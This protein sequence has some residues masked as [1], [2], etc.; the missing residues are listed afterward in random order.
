MSDSPSIY[1]PMDRRQAL[2]SGKTLPDRTVGAALF[3]DISGFTP[4]TEGLAK[5]LGRRRG[6]EELTKQLN[7]IYGGLITEVE[8][9]HGSVIGFSGD[10]ITCWLDG[11]DGLRATACAL[12]MQQVMQQ[13]ETIRTPS[14]LTFPLAIKVAIAA[15]PARRFRVGDLK[16]Q[17]WDVLAGA[18]L[19][20]LAA[21]EHEAESGEVVISAEVARQLDS[22]LQISEWRDDQ[23]SAARFAVVSGLK[24]DL[25]A[26][27]WPT[28]APDALPEEI[29]RPWVLPA[30]YERVKSGQ[31]RFQ[32]ELRPAVAL[33]LRFGGIDYDQD[34]EAGEKLDAYVH[35]VQST[36]VRY[37]GALLQLTIGDK[38]SYIYLAFGAP[39][40]H[41]DD[42]ARAALAALQ[43]RS[44][45]PELAFIEAAQIG[46]S[47]GRMRVGPYGSP[48]RRT[49][50][51]LGEHTNLAARLM[52]N[53]PPGDVLVSLA[54]QKD[55][56]A[57]FE[58]EDCPPLQV[59]G[60]AEPVI[61]FRLV[62]PNV[63][64]E[65]HLKESRY[66]L[67]LVG[68]K[69]E[70]AQVEQQLDHVF[71]GRGQILGIT[72][73]AGLGKSRLVAEIVRRASDQQMD[74]LTGECQ[75]YGTNISYHV[76]W[77]I[78]H[79]FFG[80]DPGWALEKQ[81]RSLEASLVAVS[82]RLARRLPLLGVVLNLSIP[83]N[84]LTQSMDAELRKASLEALL[85]D[86][87]RV[88]AKMNPLVFVL[89]DAHWLDPL[90]N[91]LLEVVGRA[92]ANLP[93]LILM[94]Y[95]PPELEHLQGPRVVSLPHCTVMSLTD[96]TPGEAERLIIL[97]LAQ[98]SGSETKL[99]TVFIERITERAQ[100]NPFYIEELVNYL[101]DRGID[102]SQVGALE[103]IDLPNSLHS[104]ILSRIDRL[105]ESQ[106]ITLKVASIIGRLFRRS[107][108]WGVDPELGEQTQVIADLQELSRIDLTPLDQVEPDE[109]YLFK[110]IVTREVAYESLPFATRALLHGQLG[111]FIEHF[112]AQELEQYVEL[113]AY[114]YDFSHLED[115]KREYLRKAG[116]A[117][118]AA[119][120]NEPAIDY[121]RRL[122]PLLPEDERM[123]ILLKLG[124]VLELVGEWGDAGKL[125]EQ[126]LTLA[127][128]QGNQTTLAE[129][130][131]D[132]G[133]LRRKEGDFAGAE[134]W[135]ERARRN[136][137][138][139]GDLAGAGRVLAE[140]GEVYRLKGDY[141]AAETSFQESLLLTDTVEE[142]RARL[143]AR[144]GVLKSAGTLANQ[145]G[146][147]ARARQMYEE[148][149]SILRELDDKPGVA[150]L[151][152]NLGVVAMHQEDYPTAQPLYEESLAIM[153]EIGYRWAVGQLLNNLAL[154][155]RY[156][157]DSVTAREML[158]ESVAVRRA[159][160]D[161]WGIANSLSSLTNLL[162][163]LSKYE[164]V[165]D[166]LDESLR[167]NQELGDRTAIAYCLEDFASLA[168]GT[169]HPEQALRL[170][171]AAA[172]LRADIGG[173]LAAGEQAALDRTLKPARAS[174]DEQDQAA[175]WES[176]Q[177]LSMEV[178]IAEALQGQD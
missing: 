173:P 102:P 72:A 8:R 70:L 178:A 124:D 136:F 134:T 167:I 174:L 80:L 96:F 61:V 14:G 60:K 147:L 87:V 95:R 10:A 92:I 176:G 64:Q 104:L 106:K 66:A 88:R 90:S 3:A 69:S 41:E 93:V 110:H 94:A 137:E 122:L 127:E 32:A 163:H 141:A 83:H 119:Y 150:S 103:Q 49:Y 153:R 140:I 36:A 20:R 81:V 145:Q 27:P 43:L 166:M 172:A 13:F 156:Q 75:S 115:K 1:I 24:R 12:S 5:E 105:S 91:D 44:T 31:D 112:Y 11:D 9:Y 74:I 98:V 78:W 37:D 48:E 73:E 47:K 19:D 101:H 148:S 158:E 146:D 29:V 85:V 107:W 35:W 71:A 42:A 89:D 162:V 55:A 54:A 175:A 6:A 168:A 39:V 53:A 22:D 117:A 120:A 129:S 4:L 164:G 155:I 130:Q 169:G 77:N 123:D 84:D 113:L 133:S 132:L 131:R 114:H 116:D 30:T 18:T 109:V 21:A 152:N 135:F 138:G 16:I 121:Y 62:A 160:G 100:G 56:V 82:P 33:F 170:A 26:D 149:L 40:A 15:G 99:P 139:L 58:W 23:A 108:L 51:V 67:P 86:C 128:A 50:G 143:P 177:A 118:Q 142:R 144:A 7:M 25:E 79:D 97:K 171:G 34:D 38:G 59:K 154:V 68:R 17:Y 46:I 126:A 157:G 52:Q 125:Y 65:S 57:A 159:L 161:K 63:R 76:W 111:V 45:P 165:R 2:A 151:L 28:L